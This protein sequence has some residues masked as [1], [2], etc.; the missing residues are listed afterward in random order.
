M[1]FSG[2]AYGA[3][4]MAYGAACEAVQSPVTKAFAE[5]AAEAANKMSNVM[6][7]VWDATRVVTQE[8][9]GISFQPGRGPMP[10]GLTREAFCL[11]EPGTNPRYSHVIEGDGFLR[12]GFLQ[13]AL[14]QN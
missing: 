5:A 14:V 10:T 12:D 8:L 4:G 7:Q 13:D 2:M 9:V 11:A 6:Y 3:A 1:N